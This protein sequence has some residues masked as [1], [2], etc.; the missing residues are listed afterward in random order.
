MEVY[1]Q[2]SAI[3]PLL[4]KGQ[5][6]RLSELTCKILK[7]TGRLTGQEI[8]GTFHSHPVGVATLGRPIVPSTFVLGSNVSITSSSAFS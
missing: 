4:P 3:E 6:G 8:V 7:A 2:P 5:S 1:R